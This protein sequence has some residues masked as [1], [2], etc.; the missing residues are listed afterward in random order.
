M[1]GLATTA[2]EEG[3]DAIRAAPADDGTVEMI[4]RRP[5]VDAR[6]V[7]A[8]AGIE[9]GG[10]LEGD[11]WGA[12]PHPQAEAEITVMNA[13]AAA[14]LA[15]GERARWPLAGDQL[16]VDLDLSHA[17][18]PAG[19]RLRVGAALLEVSARP[20]TGCTKFS[21]RFGDEA[22]AF[23][24]SHEGKA[25][26]LRGMNCRVVEGGVVRTDDRVTRA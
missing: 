14:L 23:V 9:P 3:L 10:G 12:R 16:Y 20:H 13:R 22:L 25:L 8:S 24:N 5:V 18:L 2:L 17:N 7:V 11:S 19:T 26:R 6:E 15:G 21:A 1:T 4:V